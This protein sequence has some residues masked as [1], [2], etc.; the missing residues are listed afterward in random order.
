MSVL[1]GRATH[2]PSWRKEGLTYAAIFFA[3]LSYLAYFTRL[4]LRRVRQEKLDYEKV[5]A[6]FKRCEED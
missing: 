1:I 2:T 5:A 4:K 3:L 6:Y